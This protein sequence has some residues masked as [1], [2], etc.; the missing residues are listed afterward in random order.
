MKFRV[1]SVN[2]ALASV[3]ELCRAG[4]RVTFDDAGSFIQN[5]K[6]G[7]VIQLYEW[8]NTYVFPIQVVPKTVLSAMG[9]T[10]LKSPQPFPRPANKL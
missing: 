3:K 2:K 8:N 5:K 6:T 7:E 1:C 9:H 10:D 4:N